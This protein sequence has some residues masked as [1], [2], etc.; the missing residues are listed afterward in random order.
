MD[1]LLC[2]AA[3]LSHSIL[4][5]GRV[6]A[7][8]LWCGIVNLRKRNSTNQFLLSAVSEQYIRLLNNMPFQLTVWLTNHSMQ[9][10]LFTNPLEMNSGT[11]LYRVIFKNLLTWGM[12]L[13]ALHGTAWPEGMMD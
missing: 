8:G 13:R 4:P 12:V 6:P 2:S 9:S 10:L 7:W 3:V 5:V 11:P 1:Q